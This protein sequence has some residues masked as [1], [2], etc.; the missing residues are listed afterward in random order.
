MDTNAAVLLFL[1]TQSARPACPPST[2]IILGGSGQPGPAGPTG[3]AGPQG[4][5]GAAGPMGPEGPQGIM[6]PMGP[7]GATGST[8]F[9]SDLTHVLGTNFQPG[10]PYPIGSLMAT[11]QDLEFVF[12]TPIAFVGQQP[13]GPDVVKVVYHD[14]ATLETW[15]A[16]GS[17]TINGAV[18][19]WS[20]DPAALQELAARLSPLG[21]LWIDV[22]CD[23]LIDSMGRPVSGSAVKAMIPAYADALAPG[24]IFRT[25]IL[26]DPA[27]PPNGLAHVSGLN[28]NPAT[29]HPLNAV[30]P[31]LQSLVFEFSRPLDPGFSSQFQQGLVSVIYEDPSALTVTYV[32]G[33]WNVAGNQLLWSIT[34]AAASALGGMLTAGSRVRI[35]VNC[36]YLLDAAG[37]PVSGSAL[38]VAKPSSTS[39]L[40]PGG[41]FRSWI[42]MA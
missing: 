7:T 10:L 2:P 1:A 11:L 27:S 39:A 26:V 20:I 24:G 13:F 32:P 25:W 31:L 29:S 33:G 6:G 36:D 4:S 3:P 9:P 35:E 17:Y 16:P 40:P 18:L 12:S 34:P 30:I 21:M 38:R 28:F 5:I 15:C 8:V 41:V 14:R 37:L 19:S 22:A 23:Y 42:Y